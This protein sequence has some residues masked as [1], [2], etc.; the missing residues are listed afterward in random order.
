MSALRHVLLPLA[1]GVGGG[2]PGG[3][4]SPGSAFRRRGPPPG[5]P[6]KRGRS[7]PRSRRLVRRRPYRHAARRGCPE[8]VHCCPVCS[9]LKIYHYIT[10]AYVFPASC[11]FIARS[12][13]FHPALPSVHLRGRIGGDIRPR[14][15]QARGDSRAQR[16]LAIVPDRRRHRLLDLRL[17]RSRTRPVHRVRTPRHLPTYCPR[18]SGTMQPLRIARCATSPARPTV[19]PARSPGR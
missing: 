3:G 17:G 2:L 18:W 12:D 6:R 10:V 14:Q 9:F 19:R 8:R 11:V 1:G 16:L 15:R 7:L 4:P 13:V 5:L